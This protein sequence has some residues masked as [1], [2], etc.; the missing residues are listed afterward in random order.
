MIPEIIFIIAIIISQLCLGIRLF[1]LKKLIGLEIKKYLYNVWLNIIV[2]SCIASI[3]PI[4]LSYKT[5][6]SLKCFIFLSLI[7]IIIV[8]LVELFIGCSAKE[9]RLLKEKMLKIINKKLNTRS[10]N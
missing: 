7:S 6:E 9:R 4:W 10:I 2:V 3:I 8:C 5:Q 1:I